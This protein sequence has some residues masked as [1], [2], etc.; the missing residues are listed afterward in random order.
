MRWCD[1]LLHCLIGSPSSDAR[2]CSSLIAL[3][4]RDHPRLP[5]PGRDGTACWLDILADHPQTR[6]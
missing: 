1:S 2:C 5:R 6:L 3:V 4:D